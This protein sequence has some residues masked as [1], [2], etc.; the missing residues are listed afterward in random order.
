MFVTMNFYSFVCHDA[1]SW[2]EFI[3]EFAIAPNVWRHTIAIV[4]RLQKFKT[5]LGFCFCL[6]F[7]F[8]DQMTISFKCF[9]IL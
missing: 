3:I 4:H 8:G 1:R 7:L 2:F 5:I 6:V 9:I